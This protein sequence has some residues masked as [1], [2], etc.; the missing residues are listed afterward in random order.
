MSGF[1]QV[2]QLLRPYGRY[3]I[4]AL[5]I[6]LLLTVL[7]LPG[8]YITKLLL[9]D[10][11]PHQDYGLLQFLLVGGAGLSLFLGFVQVS[12]GFFGRQVGLGMSLDLQTRLY[13]HV[14]SLDFCFF[15]GRETGEILS[16]FDDLD[17]SV[18]GVIHIANTMIINSLQLLV[19]PAVLLWIQPTLALLSL[20][21]LPF[22]AALA[23]VSG[24]FSKI[25]ARRI[26]EQAAAL[27]AKTV[28]S[29]S[30]IRTIQ[31][32]C[33]EGVFYGRIRTRFEDLAVVQVHATALDSLIGFSATA[34]RTGG[35][36]AYGWYGWSQVL[37]GHMTPGTFLA[38]SAYAAFLYGPMHQLITLWPR[39]Q[40][41]RV[42]VERFL[43]IYQRVPLIVSVP[44]ALRPTRLRGGIDFDEVAFGYEGVPV[45]RG[46]SVHFAAGRTTA[47]IG[48]SGAGKSTLVQLIPRFYDP[49]EGH[50]RIDGRPLQAYDVR[51][52]RRSI[53]FAMQGGSLFHGTVRE[54]LTM[55][56]DISQADLEDAARWA[57]IHEHIAQLA[58]AY[59]TPLGAGGAGMSS[60]QLQRLA[61]ARVLLQNTPVLI[62]DE[63]TSALDQETETHVRQ[64]LRR[65]CEGRTTI[66]IAHR[67]ETISMADEVVQLVNGRIVHCA[68][69]GPVPA[70]AA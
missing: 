36:L 18:S 35:A 60:G 50:I 6:S 37:G 58:L 21:V 25:F 33:A 54:N 34:L 24:H 61:L 44:H 29:L 48:E 5:L 62:L 43:E 19:F 2:L 28:E 10:A 49:Q 27:S 69:A 42:H 38:F 16:R 64:A 15:D 47:L 68:G 70:L 51:A 1:G 13:R 46:A 14:Q 59:D 65:A 4:Q 39:V 53:G 55:G 12:A 41:V 57:C 63:P 3:L 52:L 7:A 20:V 40:T 31:S 23:L 26:A 11:Y 22:D 66:L 32:L 30:S 45:L 9:D 67:P 8:P 17:A 56:Q